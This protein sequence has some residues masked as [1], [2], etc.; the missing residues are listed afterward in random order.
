MHV[1]RSARVS[2][3]QK[4]IKYQIINTH[5]ECI[6]MG[7]LSKEHMYIKFET[8]LTHCECYYTVQNKPFC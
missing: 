4:A 2:L 7:D 1:T 5:Q 6:R 8:K 3:Q